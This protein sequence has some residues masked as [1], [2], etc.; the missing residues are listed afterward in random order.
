MR[1]TQET[2]EKAVS[3][4]PIP[5]YFINDDFDEK[6]VCLQLDF[7]KENGVEAFFF[8]V[9]DGIVGEAFGTDLFYTHAKF[10]VDEAAKRGMK[11]W[12]Y[13]EDAYPS[14]NC[15]GLAVIDHPELQMQRLC[16]LRVPVDEKGI[17]RAKIGKGVGVCGY[18]LS[19]DGKA[20]I[21]ENCFGAV[22]T[23][24]HQRAMDKHYFADMAD[25][26]FAHTRA[27]TSY[28]EVLF[29][30]Q[31]PKDAEVYCVYRQP[32]ATDIRYGTLSNTLD[33][34]ATDYFLMHVHEK[35]REFVGEYFGNVIPGVF[36]DEPA[37]GG[38]M[39]CEEL[40][41][42]FTER[43]GYSPREEYYK[44]SPE[45]QGE[46][47]K[48]RR[49]Y[50]TVVSELFRKN[51][52][53]P[54]Q[55][56][57]DK[58]GLILTGHFSGE[59]NLIAQAHGGD[60]YSALGSFDIPGMDLIG[61]DVGDLT[62]PSMLLGAKIASSAAWQSGK[63]I[64][65]S[66]SFGLNPYNF[67]YQGMKINADWLYACGV[68]LIIPHA[69]H[70]G[71][72][73]FRRADA[74]KS[75]FF[76]DA[77]FG[78]Y[79][80]FSAYA[81][82]VGK[83]LHEYRAQ[84]PCL[85][86]IPFAACAEEMLQYRKNAHPTPTERMQGILNRVNKLLV[87]LYASHIDFDITYSDKALQATIGE[88]FVR[89]GEKTYT[90]VIVIEGGEV[91]KAVYERFKGGMSATK[92]FTDDCSLPVTEQCFTQI[93]GD[94]RNVLLLKK[95]SE[96]GSLYF[97][98]NNGEEYVKFAFAGEQPACAYD[99]EKDEYLTFERGGE[100]ALN[101]YQSMIFLS[102]ER[103][104]SGE[105]LPPRKEKLVR[106]YKEQPQRVFMP[107]GGKAAITD[108]DLTVQTK[109]GERIYTKVGF[110]RLRDILGTTDSAVSG[111]IIPY[112]DTAPRILAPY[113]VAAKYT[114]RMENLGGG[115][116]FDKDTISGDYRL[117]FNGVEITQF[118]P[119]RVYDKSNLIFYPV[120]KEGE[121]ILEIVFDEGEE[122][123]GINGEF[124]VME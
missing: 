82:R 35:Y 94:I 111:Y 20:T 122:Y 13:D 65:M 105:Y 16:V 59:E 76:Q 19:D 18:V 100:I 30:T 121:N 102:E 10:V 24:W 98:F 68:N 85:V 66:E 3:F 33:R 101:G 50:A 90:E 83:L 22:R 116:L 67:G 37:M 41:G 45:Y 38:A 40:E 63:D 74:G 120:W 52:L 89:V 73:A 44:L 26:H 56:W 4:Q 71:Y 25:R 96:K 49:D 48:F 92:L 110:S 53:T 15:G 108:F 2:I 8:H 86:V 12:L 109:E 27:A 119:K 5:F 47:A 51:F 1:K 97:L 60:I 117:L 62:H 118:I 70:Y 106:P 14:G 64:I 39:Y 28:A 79:K 115:I 72:S 17:A 61:N 9:R 104:C 57:C 55:E 23:T 78:E 124:F 103:A 123:D 75:F 107:V 58:Q 114:A 42:Y 81:T 113:P 34:R 46:S 7:M 95:Q 99:A 77:L 32:V 54:I 87:A 43:M 6:E 88:K 93:E 69:F 31:A 21:V 112:F 91:E 29:E 80:Q 84:N 36:L 11:V